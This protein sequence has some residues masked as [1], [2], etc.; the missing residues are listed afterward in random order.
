VAQSILVIDDDPDICEI[1]RINLEGAG[2]NV[3]VATDGVAGLTAVRTLLP[4]LIILDVLMPGL[5]GW[6]VLEAIET[7]PVTA[8]RP[9]IMLT[10][11]GGDQ[12]VL[13]GLGQ[14]AVEY[15]TKPFFP[16][17]LVASVKILLEVFDASMRDQRRQHL[18]ARRQRAIGMTTTASVPF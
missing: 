18:I 5:D 4:D 9:V 11:K 10:C 14:G 15:F 6:Q 17:N 3:S 16:E 8:G 12:D 7:D 2:Y 13:R 1:V